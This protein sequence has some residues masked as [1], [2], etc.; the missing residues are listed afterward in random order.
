M[1][2][3]MLTY[4]IEGS[5]GSWVRAHSLARGLVSNGHHV[6]IWCARQAPRWH[7]ESPREPDGS[8]ATG[9]D[10][11]EVESFGGV[12]VRRLRHGGLD[13][14]ELGARLR[15]ARRLGGTPGRPFDLVHGFG[16]RPTVAWTGRA[17]RRRLGVPYLADWAD[18]WGMDGIGGR[19]KGASRAILGRADE[20]WERRVYSQVDGLSVITSDLARR[21]SRFRI[22]EERI[23][24]CPVGADVKAI[25]P[26]DR[27]TARARAGLPSS[28]PIAC[29]V[30]F[31]NYDAE[32]LA[33]SFVALARRV[34][35]VC[36]LMVGIQLPEFDAIVERAGLARRVIHCGVV[37]HAELGPLLAC[38]DVMLLPYL[39]RA[40]NRGRYPNKIGDYMAAGRP[41][42][43]NATGDLRHLVE[44]S[45]CGV[46][47]GEDP[48]EF[49]DAAA[50]LLHDPVRA[51]AVGARA[52]VAAEQKTSWR[53]LAADLA[54]F[55]Q[56]VSRDFRPERAGPGVSHSVG[57]AA[58]QWHLESSE[59]GEESRGDF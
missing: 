5:G 4:E 42:V 44:S 11:V 26:G 25:V 56:R 35:E 34:P 13:P 17:L 27:A 47:A 57:D 22:A 1:R 52:R 9:V 41:T 12:L 16:H 46:L 32:Y 33:Q 29:Y 53:A 39:D 19:R 51:E 7:E 23:H 36:M 38:A 15:A 28:A 45:G 2:V 21:A 49:A 48:E 55:Y 54:D 3:L 50:G 18:L 31:N 58:G 24:L 43:A 20:F 6:T 10:G 30:G 40:I 14:V 59:T 37:P 8:V